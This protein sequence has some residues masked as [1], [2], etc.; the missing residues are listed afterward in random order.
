[1]VDTSR[2]TEVID[3]LSCDMESRPAAPGPE[4]LQPFLLA[5]SRLPG[6]IAWEFRPEARDTLREFVAAEQVCCAGLSWRLFEG[7]ALRLEIGASE[8]QLDAIATIFAI[9]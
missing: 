4:E 1:M 3:V 9:A 7:D 8:P 6:V 5:V 2:W